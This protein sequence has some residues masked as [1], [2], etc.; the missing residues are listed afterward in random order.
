VLI[1]RMCVKET[2]WSFWRDGHPF[3]TKAQS[4]TSAF[5]GR[6]DARALVTFAIATSK[7]AGEVAAVR[8]A[9]AEDLT[10]RFGRGHWS[11]VPT[12]RGV[13]ADMRYAR[14]LVGRSI[15]DQIVAVLRLAARK[16]WAI[17][18][19][20]FTGCK[21]PLYLTDMAVAP[22]IQRCG[23]GRALLHEALNV[24]HGWPADAIRLDAYDA[25]A[26][27]GGFY[28]RCGFEE[29]GRAVYRGVPLIYFER[30]LRMS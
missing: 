19:A 23:V 6:D 27:A 22:T 16:P 2:A 3:S 10:R 1:Y 11:S 7:D 14:I 12:V 8:G 18:V 15:D 25:P 9:A 5:N 21:R 26:G 24:A 13:R 28:A 29:R 20:Y 17:D 30:R 4:S